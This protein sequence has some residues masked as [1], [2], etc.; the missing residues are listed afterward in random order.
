MVSQE[1]WRVFIRSVCALATRPRLERPLEIDKLRRI[2]WQAESALR[3]RETAV[4][5]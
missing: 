5:E 3:N 4:R 1:T 2:H